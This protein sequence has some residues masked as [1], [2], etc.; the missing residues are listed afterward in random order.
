MSSETHVYLPVRTSLPSTA[1]CTYT[2][3]KWRQ[4][5]RRTYLIPDILLSILSTV[6]IVLYIV[7][8]VP[9]TVLL[10]GSLD[11][12]EVA[13]V[14]I[15]CF[16][17][18]PER[19]KAGHFSSFAL[20]GREFFYSCLGTPCGTPTAFWPTSHEPREQSRRGPGHPSLGRFTWAS[21]WKGPVSLCLAHSRAK[22]AV[23]SRTT[24]TLR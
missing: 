15:G 13:Q 23:H 4:N 22:G 17:G 10:A 3:C 20:D 18:E 9:Y 12:P 21:S 14:I 19:P 16:V 1:L 11:I 7:L 8:C 6:H 5:P 24:A 2:L